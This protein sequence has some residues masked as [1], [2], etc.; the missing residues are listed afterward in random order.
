M[1]G[2]WLAWACADAPVGEPS[3]PAAS[4]GPVAVA[5]ARSEDAVGV[6]V[7]PRDAT[8]SAEV[9][10]VLVTMT[11]DIGSR[12]SAGEPLG[13]IEPAS[14]GAEVQAVS[15]ELEAARVAE[16]DARAVQDAAQ[17][18]AVAER[19]LRAEG[20]TSTDALADAELA[21]ARAQASVERATAVVRATEA[22]LGGLQAELERRHLRAPFAGRI[23]Q[24]LRVPGE[25]VAVGDR[26]VR[27]VGEGVPWVR[28][29]VVPRV[30][31]SLAPG[32]EVEVRAEGGDE[33]GTAEVVRVAPEVDAS[34][35]LVFVEAR[36]V[37]PTAAV[38]G[39]DAWVRMP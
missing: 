38:P 37:E 24:W 25:H 18:R 21:V 36:M 28:F 16:A 22:R 4:V 27:V 17:R 11:H 7:A 9:G 8:V 14:R 12:V 34:S 23:A 39:Q 26:V 19:G 1:I 15:R 13:S 20:A 3:E 30:A 10:G 29:A 35:Q 31:A 2:M 32:R 5:A 6:V 33:L